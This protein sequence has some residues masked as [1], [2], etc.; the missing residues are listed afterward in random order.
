MFSVNTTA[1]KKKLLE[2]HHI[3]K[4]IHADGRCEGW[5]EIEGLGRCYYYLRDPQASAYLYAAAQAM[6][7]V[8]TPLMLLHQANVY[9]MAQAPAEMEQCLDQLQVLTTE[10]PGRSD[11]E[12]L[13]LWDIRAVGEFIAGHDQACLDLAA[14]YRHLANDTTE[15]FIY[16]IE[17]L[18]DAR[19]NSIPTKAATIAQ[20]FAQTIKKE[21]IKPWDT[22][23]IQLWDLY[24]LACQIA[25]PNP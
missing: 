21:R 5:Y 24:E 11:D 7:V 25:T 9:R 18:A 13:G 23:H 6:K 16:A 3:M 10:Q 8:D 2:K 20:E 15:W 17:D 4:I 1:I 22:D 19:L 12:Q 14:Q